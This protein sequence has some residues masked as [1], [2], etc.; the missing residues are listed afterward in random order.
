MTTGDLTLNNYPFKIG[1]RARGTGHATQ[2]DSDASAVDEN[3]S[4]F[5][6]EIDEAMVFNIG[7]DDA[8]A[9]TIYNLF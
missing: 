4:R 5:F 3:G 6:G 8:M 9:A 1:A 2:S 7:V